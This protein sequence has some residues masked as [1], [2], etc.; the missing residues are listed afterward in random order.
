MFVLKHKTVNS[1][2]DMFIPDAVFFVKHGRLH[3]TIVDQ[4]NSRKNQQEQ[5]LRCLQERIRLDQYCF[6][7]KAN[8][9][10]QDVYSDSH[11]EIDSTSTMEC[12]PNAMSIPK[13]N[14]DCL[15]LIF[16]QVNLADL[17][18]LKRS[19]IRF[20]NIVDD[21]FKRYKYLYVDEHT[22]KKLTLLEIRTLEANELQSLKPLKNKERKKER[23]KKYF[24]WCGTPLM[25][26]IG[27]FHAN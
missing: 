5:I 7:N 12:M 4:R 26:L 9:W 6:V 16:K 17:I 10:L 27:P 20:Q 18:S 13:L 25:D 21:L 19:S 22:H 11:K 15:I 8:S 23:N 14:D 2:V 1:S 3:T 24:N